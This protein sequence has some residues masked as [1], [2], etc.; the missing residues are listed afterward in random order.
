MIIPDQKR[1]S[2]TRYHDRNS[3]TGGGYIPFSLSGTEDLPIRRREY[4]S[5]RES[6]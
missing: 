1:L 2:L 6:I 4:F 5:W 3:G